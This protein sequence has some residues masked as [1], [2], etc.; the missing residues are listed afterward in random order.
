MGEPTHVLVYNTD[1][2]F[3]KADYP[4]AEEFVVHAA[5]FA[6]GRQS[7]ARPRPPGWPSFG[8]AGTVVVEVYDHLH[9]G[10]VAH[11]HHT[12]SDPYDG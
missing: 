2:T 3:R 5:G 1:G 4:D 9:D 11:P 6:I 12:A 7:S 10:P 8:H